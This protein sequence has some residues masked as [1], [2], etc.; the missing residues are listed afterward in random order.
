MLLIIAIAL[1]RWLGKNKFF[2]YYAEGKD[3][4]QTVEVDHDEEI[5]RISY[6]E[7]LG[8]SYPY[9]I[10]GFLNYGITLALF[11]GLTSLGN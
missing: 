5:D 11:P 6:L 2:L 10:S 3:Q 1:T 8:N 7:L 4:F 9:L